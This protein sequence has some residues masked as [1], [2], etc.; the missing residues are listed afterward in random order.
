M[1]QIAAAVDFGGTKLMAGFVDETGTVLAG[2]TVPTPRAGGPEAVADEAARL[3]KYLAVKHEIP[4]AGLAGVG[5][6]V[7]GLADGRTG[8]MRYAP[9]HGWRDVPW[10]QM[11]TARLGLPARIANDVNACALAEQ[12]FGAGRGVENLV[13]IT[14]STGIGGGLVLNGQIF[15][16]GGGIAGE[17]GHLVVNE[18]GHRCGCGHL[19]CLE[20]EAAGPAIARRAREAGLEAG[21]AGA[22]AKLVRI[23]D[24]DA[25][26]VMHD[27]AVYLGR[28]IAWVCNILDPDLVV[29]GGGVA[30]SLDVL[31]PTI[32]ATVR[33]RAI[34]L[35]ERPPQIVPTALGYEAALIGAAALVL[36]GP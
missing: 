35:P 23:G 9:A 15:E 26:R 24:P 4:L 1:S 18:G 8:V 29:L 3:L 22:V 30:R 34:L 32:A 2:D 14:V 7:P 12:R 11:L 13:W 17:I 31:L 28:G 25:R 6:T 21:D 10:A 16:G 36:A 19:G 20:A 5:S 33:D 27:T